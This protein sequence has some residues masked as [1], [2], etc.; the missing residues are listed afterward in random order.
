MSEQVTFSE[1]DIVRFKES[2]VDA[3]GEEGNVL[4]GHEALIVNHDWDGSNMVDVILSKDT[5]A[6]L[7]AEY[8]NWC[9]ELGLIEDEI[10]GV[11]V[12][13]LELVSKAE[14]NGLA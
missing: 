11:K 8:F 5:I 10:F 3:E 14:E 2:Y 7:P 13:D 12:D 9:Y 6:A 1:G 4:R